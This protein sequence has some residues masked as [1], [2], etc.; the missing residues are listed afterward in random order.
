MGRS[1][2]RAKGKRRFAG[3]PEFRQEL[4]A[5]GGGKKKARAAISAGGAP[6]PMP[7]FRSGGP[8]FGNGGAVTG[9]AGMGGS[10]GGFGSGGSV[11][12]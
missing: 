10:L 2:A 1:K 3:S 5:K 7:A 4:A 12:G 9:Y 8:G 11:Y 6:A